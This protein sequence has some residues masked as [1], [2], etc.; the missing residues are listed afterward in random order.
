MFENPTVQF[1]AVLPS[2]NH[3]VWCGLVK[4]VKYRN[5]PYAHRWRVLYFEDSKA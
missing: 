1:G 3:K 4:N 5:A 2:R